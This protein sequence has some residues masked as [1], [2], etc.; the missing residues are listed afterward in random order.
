MRGSCPP[1]RP[2][3]PCPRRRRCAWP[4]AAG[5]IVSIPLQRLADGDYTVKWRILADDGHT[6]EGVF[7]FAVGAGRAPPQAALSAGGSPTTRDVLSRWL[8]FAGLLVAVGVAIFLPLAWR[9]A[10]R[11]AG[12]ARAGRRLPGIYLLGFLLPL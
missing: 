10:L 5:R 1:R 8:F 4:C 3:G 2:T 12:A 6:E 9:P 11:A 7:A